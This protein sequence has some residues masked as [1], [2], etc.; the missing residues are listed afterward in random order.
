M[1]VAG[2]SGGAGGPAA[3]I[4]SLY[5]YNCIEP[6]GKQ[7]RHHVP[8]TPNQKVTRLKVILAV[9]EMVAKYGL[10]RVGLLTLSFGVPGSGKGSYETWSLR[11][12]AKQWKFVQARW[13]SFRTN[14][15]AKRYEDWIC[16]F[17]LHRD[18]VWHIHVIVVTKADIRTGT[19]I[20][21]LSN[22]NLPYWKRRGK[23]LRNEALS[24]EWQALRLICCRYRFGRS[25]LLPVKKSG[26]ALGSYL[27]NYLVK[28]YA[29]L[30]AGQRCRLVRFSR[31]I[32][33]KFRDK[34]AIHSLG[35]LLYRTRVRIVA[36]MLRFEDYEDFAEFFGPRWHYLLKNVIAWVPIPFRF[37]KD[38]F[39][40]GMSARVL[41]AYAQAPKQ[42]L[43]ERGKN[44]IDDVA[45]ELWRRLEEA[46]GENSEELV[47]LRSRCMSDNAGDGPALADEMQSDLFAD[48]YIPF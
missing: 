32:G 45:R 48:P 1:P 4:P 44:K 41:L 43:D 18:G 22:Y 46:L 33:E 16:V 42:F 9:E 17:E 47:R 10:E 14:V 38:D 24:E 20:E 15:I 30:P 36:Q 8:L 26:K 25:E 2:P 31:Q 3:G 40:S 35:G 19:N 29:Q 23:H 7:P 13:H 27:A 39:G 11:Q 12:Q 34:F 21:T 28:T 37:H 6:V 5:C